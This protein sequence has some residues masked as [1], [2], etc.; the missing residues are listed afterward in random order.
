MMDDK[1]GSVP[2]QFAPL[3]LTH[4]FDLFVLFVGSIHITSLW[5]R[6]HL[7]NKLSYNLL[8]LSINCNHIQ[9][10]PV[11]DMYF[12]IYLLNLSSLIRLPFHLCQ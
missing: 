8:T 10:I 3:L 2:I 12:M 7:M 4:L 11:I 5:R 6:H 9:I 1:N